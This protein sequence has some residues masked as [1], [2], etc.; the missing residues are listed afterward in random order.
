[1]VGA[2]REHLEGVAVAQGR[3]SDADRSAWLAFGQD[4]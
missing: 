3:R 4:L 1:L 2:V